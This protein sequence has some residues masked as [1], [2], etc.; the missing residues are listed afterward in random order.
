MFP[1]RRALILVHGCLWR[2]HGC[3][4]SAIPQTRRDFW[5]KKLQDHREPDRRALIALIASGR[6]VI[7]V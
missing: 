2:A 1:E 4:L 7:I 6:R 3:P 5:E